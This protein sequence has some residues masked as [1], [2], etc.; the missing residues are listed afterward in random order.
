MYSPDIARPLNAKDAGRPRRVALFLHQIDGRAVSN[1]VLS[2]A[3]E[4]L[5]LCSDVHVVTST[6]LPDVHLPED[7]TVI[8]LGGGGKRTTWSIPALRATLKRLGT[9]IVIAHCNGPARAAILATRGMAVP[10]IVITVEHTHYSSYAWSY[11]RLRRQLNAA[12]LPRA[13]CV[14]GVSPDVAD[15]L[16]V[17][18]P[19]LDSRVAMIPPPLARWK[20]LEV[21]AK[22]PVQHPWFSDNVP[23]ITTVGNLNSHK[24]QATLIRALAGFNR[25]ARASSSQEARL[26]IIGRPDDAVVEGVLRSLTAEL[27]L[28]KSVEFL[29][30]QD[31]PLKF[32]ARSNIFALSS[33]SEGAPVAI[34]EALALGVPVVSTNLGGPAWLLEH[35]RC[36]ILAPVG[37][38]RQMAEAIQSALDDPQLRRRL[39]TAGLERVQRFAPKTIAE[40][41]LALADHLS[42]RRAMSGQE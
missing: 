25:R 17:N 33:R 37:D 28:E 2:L 21:L 15:D 3:Q 38:D 22:E 30:F 8:D 29:G 35:G 5:H 20:T 36:G 32:V 16:I 11:P 14:V 1:V 4:L 24:D 19:S 26:L 27:A 6:V 18:F 10:P 42:S 12:L 40:E 31:N 34:L 13:H 39:V 23:I 7:V 41:Y 9:E